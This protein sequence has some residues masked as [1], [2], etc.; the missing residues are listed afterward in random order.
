MLFPGENVVSLVPLIIPS[1]ARALIASFAQAWF[2]RSTKRSVVS[3]VSGFVGLSGVSASGFSG[4]EGVVGVVDVP[5][6]PPPP[7]PDEP[8]VVEP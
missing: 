6:P 5:V 3:E 7:P 8:P 4:V 1:S 2:P